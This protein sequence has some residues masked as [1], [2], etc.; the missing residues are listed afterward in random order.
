MELFY[1]PA[2]QFSLLGIKLATCQQPHGV[3][4]LFEVRNLLDIATILAM[5]Y[6]VNIILQI[7]LLPSQMKFTWRLIYKM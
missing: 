5:T 3:V 7:T 4:L 2:K 6:S 1:S